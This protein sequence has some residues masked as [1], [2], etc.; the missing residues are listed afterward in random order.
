MILTLHIIVALASIAF[1]SYTYM[2]PSTSKLYGTYGLIVATFGS[3]TYLIVA[4]PS[5]LLQACVVGI[6]YLTVVGFVALA[7]R[8]KLASAKNQP[9]V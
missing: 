2:R 5:H 7:A 3:G 1:A 4:S 6:A 8:A 9:L